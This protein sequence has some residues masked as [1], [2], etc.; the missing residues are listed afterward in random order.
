MQPPF[1]TFLALDPAENTL[2]GSRIAV[3]P[4]PY[5]ETVSYRPGTDAGPAAIIRAS[6]EMEDYDPELGR[7]PCDVGIHTLPAL[8]P[9]GETPEAMAAAVADAVDRLTTVG[10]MVCMLG[11]EHSLTAGAVEGVARSVGDL[12]VLI[13]DAQADLRDD[14][15]GWR[16]S[17]ACAARRVLDHAPVTLVGVRS[18][19]TDEAAFIDARAVP[20]FPR[21]AEPITDID[22]IVATLSPNVYI[23]VDLDALDPSIMAA[24]GTPEPGGML[25]W[26]TLRIL[27]AVADRRRIVG[28]DLMELAP[29]EGPEACAYTAAKLAYK[30]MAYAT[31]RPG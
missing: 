28:F 15:Q 17:H 7:E 24:V 22:A 11:G 4:I 25:W 3:L 29:S 1:D 26:E 21:G 9:A 27:Q 16:Y 20:C 14:Y 13:L 10:T 23:S 31:A 5:A 12:S 18:M 2:A 6:A 30:L 19:T 8:T